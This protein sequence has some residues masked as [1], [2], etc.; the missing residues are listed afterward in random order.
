MSP[1]EVGAFHLGEPQNCALEPRVR[2]AHVVERHILKENTYEPECLRVAV[3]ARRVGP[4]GHFRARRA[5]ALLTVPGGLAF[6]EF[7]GYEDWAVVAVHHTED[8][9]KVVVG[10][11]ATIGAFRSGIPGN[12][13]P[14]P[15]GSKMAK[16]EWKPKKISDAP[17]DVTVPGTVYDLDFMVKDAR[18]PR[19]AADG[20]MPCLKHDVAASRSSQPHELTSR[21]R[22]TTPSVAPRAT[23]LRRPKTMSLRST[24]CGD[25]AGPKK[26]LAASVAEHLCRFVGPAFRTRERLVK[27]WFSG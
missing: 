6:S 20:E 25:R 22:A 14:F 11:P 3:C 4:G 26:A 10:N 7:K 24:A 2:A 13:K 12:G 8:L 15:D 23:P 9:V 19:T 18:V 27:P 5:Y 1:Y 16:V 17:F 21:R